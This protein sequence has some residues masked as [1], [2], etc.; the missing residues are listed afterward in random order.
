MK[1][2]KKDFNE[3]KLNEEEEEEEIIKKLKVE[4]QYK[5]KGIYFSR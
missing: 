1:R 4:T 2:T 5:F 3:L